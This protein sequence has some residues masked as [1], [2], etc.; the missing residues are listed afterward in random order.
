MSAQRLLR[1]QQLITAD[2]LTITGTTS[3]PFSLCFWGA[4]VLFGILMMGMETI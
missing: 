3:D 2:F 4:Y 1:L